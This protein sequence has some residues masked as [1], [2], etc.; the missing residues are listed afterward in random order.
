MENKESHT[1]T[2]TKNFLRK[3]QNYIFQKFTSN[4]H[5]S[6]ISESKAN[7]E[8]NASENSVVNDK[9]A[10][11]TDKTKLNL[12]ESGHETTEDSFGKPQSKY[13]TS[14]SCVA[15]KK[16]MDKMLKQEK[17]LRMNEYEKEIIRLQEKVLR[18]QEKICKLQQKVSTLQGVNL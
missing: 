14:E 4:A 9:E 10:I 16:E 11:D 5:A 18:L 15:S 2:G 8:E 17:N 1:P 6:D 3:F 13:I 7:L 12:N